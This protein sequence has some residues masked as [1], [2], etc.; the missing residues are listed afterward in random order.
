MACTDNSR[1]WA[2]HVAS[3]HQPH[4]ILC[5]ARSAS[6]AT[7][8]NSPLRQLQTMEDAGWVTD[9][10]VIPNLK[11]E[12][13]CSSSVER[14]R[15][16]RL[17]QGSHACSRTAILS[18]CTVLE[19]EIQIYSLYSGFCIAQFL[20]LLWLKRLYSVRMVTKST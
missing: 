5:Q 8:K 3:I 1:V 4:Y 19:H 16:S 18:V 7:T 13:F 9:S 20:Q 15:L 10:T 14:F 12:Q 11:D 2:N 17:Q 6:Q